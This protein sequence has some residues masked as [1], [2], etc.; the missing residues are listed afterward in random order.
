[1]RSTLPFAWGRYG[2]ENRCSMSSA[3]Q[4]CSMIS[5][6][7]FDPWSE[8]SS[9]NIPGKSSGVSSHHRCPLP[10]PEVISPKLRPTADKA[11]GDRSAPT[12]TPRPIAGNVHVP[13]WAQQQVSQLRRLKPVLCNT[14]GHWSNSGETARFHD[15]IGI[16]ISTGG[17]T[18]TC[19]VP[20]ESRAKPVR[21]R[22]RR[23]LP[24]FNG[25]T[26]HANVSSSAGCQYCMHQVAQQRRLPRPTT[27]IL[28]NK[29]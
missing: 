26:C 5:A 9:V 13:E 4:T 7:K 8:R 3:A 2:I 16:H 23:K 6:V 1:M 10:S 14:C 25:N 24:Q 12:L 11:V 20:C 17:V 18:N 21:A 19:R 28:K 29:V 22:S 15:K 27:P